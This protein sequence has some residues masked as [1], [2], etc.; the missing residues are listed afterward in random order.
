MTTTRTTSTEAARHR[1]WPN[2]DQE[3]SFGEALPQMAE[4]AAEKLP[5][6]YRLHTRPLM[7]AT[8]VV[9]TQFVS[10]ILISV[11]LLTDCT[12]NAREALTAYPRFT[13]NQELQKLTPPSLGFGRY[14]RTFEYDAARPHSM[15][16][17]QLICF[18]RFGLA[19]YDYNAAVYLNDSYG[20]E[21]VAQVSTPG[22]GPWPCP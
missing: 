20:G 21:C 11:M 9:G 2:L 14:T 1:R 12:H 22:I 17:G 8:L 16:A 4:R 10:T 13:L 19:Y 3:L 7:M 6:K 18:G 5:L 15:P